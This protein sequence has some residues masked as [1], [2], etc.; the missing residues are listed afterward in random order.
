VAAPA[1]LDRIPHRLGNWTGEDA[2][3]PEY[4][5]EMLS[6]DAATCR[7]YRDLGYETHAWVIYWSSRNMVKGYHHPDVCW[8]NR[9]FRMVGREVVPVR[10]AGGTIPL[11][12]REFARGRDRQLILYWTQEGRRVWT[13]DDEQAARLAI[14]SHGWL[15]ERLSGRS[16][17]EATG[18][19]VVLVGTPT[20][21][22][23]AAIRT[24]TVEFTRLLAAAVYDACP[25]ATIPPE[26][27]GGPGL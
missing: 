25:W 26:P 12:V 3:V 10:V 19:L 17:P 13:E 20:W 9:G 15:G 2:P 18:R 27:A 6:Y 11:T 23:G 8:P 16:R 14:G 21:G 1:P 24:R 4:V 7:V 5:R 22:D